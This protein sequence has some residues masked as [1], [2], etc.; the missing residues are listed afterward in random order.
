MSE[1]EDDE[2]E[3]EPIAPSFAFD[4]LTVEVSQ[5]GEGDEVQLDRKPDFDSF[6]PPNEEIEEEYELT[7]DDIPQFVQ[8]FEVPRSTL[9]EEEKQQ[10]IL[11][12]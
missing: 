8:K 6:K 11:K 4:D 12:V 1:I 3:D 2:A 7:A 10:N 5:Y 9:E